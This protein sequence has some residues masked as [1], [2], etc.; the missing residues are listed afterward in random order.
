[1][2]QGGASKREDDPLEKRGDH[3][4]VKKGIEEIVAAHFLGRRDVFC[5]S[6]FSSIHTTVTWDSGEWVLRIF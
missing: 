5:V 1:M 3:S 4:L 2:I 6:S